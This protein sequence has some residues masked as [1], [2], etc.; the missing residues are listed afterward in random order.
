[1]D[2]LLVRRGLAAGIGRAG[3]VG[4]RAKRLGLHVVGDRV[5]VGQTFR[6][7]TA[8]GMDGRILI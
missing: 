8:R 4:V 7:Q 1:M 6:E 5:D 2:A 3:Y